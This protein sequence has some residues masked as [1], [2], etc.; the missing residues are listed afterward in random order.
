MEK[1]ERKKNE[2]RGTLIN[3]YEWGF[4]SAPYNRIAETTAAVIKK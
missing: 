2:E 4:R 1:Q 3:R